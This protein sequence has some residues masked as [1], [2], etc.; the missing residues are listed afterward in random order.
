MSKYAKFTTS[1]TGY[2]TYTTATSSAE[3]NAKVGES[4]E[5]QY[6]KHALQVVYIRAYVEITRL[7]AEYE[8]LIHEHSCSE[9]VRE[10]EGSQEKALES[11]IVKMT[12]IVSSY[13]HKLEAYKL[14]IEGSYRLEVQMRSHIRI[15]AT[16]CGEMAATVSSL[17]KVRDAIHVLGVCPG[18]G[19]ITFV[20]PKWTG[21]LLVVD[22]PALGLD[23][24]A[25]TDAQIDEE[26]NRI[27]ADNAPVTTPTPTTPSPVSLAQ[28]SQG[29]QPAVVMIYRAAE[30]SELMLRSIEGMPTRN[31]ASVPLMG[32][33]PNCA[34]ADD[35]P[36]SLIQHA[37]GHQRVCWD[38][39][40]VLDTFNKR[41]DCEGG[42]KAVMCVED[43][44][45]APLAVAVPV[46][47]PVGTP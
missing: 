28:T 18:L 33:C 13:T 37:S 25:L 41:K 30:S 40:A 9:Y 11:K 1:T 34:G 16:R 31:E 32:I 19:R 21:Q 17:D 5:C 39:D 8:I 45:Y 2:G 23:W 47:P 26:L 38:P 42:R 15:L 6:Q 20:I 14:R 46:A 3:Y 44:D 24:A 27:C 4:E 12:T 29:P 36:E 10:L 7:L 22:W 35:T 43:R